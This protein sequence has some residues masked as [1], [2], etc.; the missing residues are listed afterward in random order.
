[1]AASDQYPNGAFAIAA[2]PTAWP[3]P[4]EVLPQGRS[5]FSVAP[6]SRFLY[7]A[8]PLL[9]AEAPCGGRWLSAW[10]H[11]LDLSP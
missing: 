8:V 10:A 5:R 4:S 7:H 6:P 2:A 11:E 3:D 9:M 1:M